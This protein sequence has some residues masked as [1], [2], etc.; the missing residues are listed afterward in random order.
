MANFDDEILPGEASD[1]AV[2]LKSIRRLNKI[3]RDEDA[4]MF[5]C[6]DPDLIQEQKLAPDYYE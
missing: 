2:A 3:R 4:V 1:D 5:V 6:H